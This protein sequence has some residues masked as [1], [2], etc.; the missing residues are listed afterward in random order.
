V[1]ELAQLVGSPR[2][3]DAI[4][5]ATV[6]EAAL[7]VAYRAMTGRGMRVREVVSFLGAGVALL[8]AIRVVARGGSPALFGFAMLWALGLHLWH[9]A[10]RWER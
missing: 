9:V 3:L 5:A 8:A 7:L 6:V 2:L 1:T 4:I 10:Q